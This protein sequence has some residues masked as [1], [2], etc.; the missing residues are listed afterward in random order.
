MFYIKERDEFL[1]SVQSVVNVMRHLHPEKTAEEWFLMLSG[2]ETRPSCKFCG[3][4]C[5][6]LSLSR[7]YKEWCNSSECMKEANVLAARKTSYQKRFKTFWGDMLKEPEE[8]HCVMCNGK[9]N[10]RK[11]MS[12]NNI[13][14]SAKCRSNYMNGWARFGESIPKSEIHNTLMRYLSET[15][16]PNKAVDKI[17][18]MVGSIKDLKE[19]VYGLFPFNQKT[20][21][22]ESQRIVYCEETKKYVFVSGKTRAFYKH[23]EDC[24]I[25]NEEE[26]LLVLEK[27]LP[28]CIVRCSYC[29]EPTAV[30]VSGVLL[31]SNSRPTRSFCNNDHYSKFMKENPDLYE[32][33]DER[34]ENQSKAMID[35]ISKGEFTPNPTNSWIRSD[36]IIVEGISFKSSWEALFYRVINLVSPL[37]YE[38]VR[39]PYLF[40]GKKRNYLVDFEDFDRKILYEVKPFSEFKR[41]QNQIKLDTAVEWCDNMGYKFIHVGEWWFVDNLDILESLQGLSEKEIKTIL[42]FKRKRNEYSKASTCK[43]DQ[44]DGIIEGS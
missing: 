7:G 43:V 18:P 10:T 35:K 21:I 6:F 37:N 23:L 15:K 12:T 1:Q 24:G 8:P 42:Q 20:P 39:I 19:N 31:E 14:S 40:G 34:K 41:I 27:T 16:I 13:C 11:S 3:K 28:E 4:P 5:G 29:N 9:I 44:T 32:H 17:K 36:P 33:T 38:N 2:W 30:Y 25:V 22:S 26:K